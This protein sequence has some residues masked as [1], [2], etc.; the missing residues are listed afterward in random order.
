MEY[1]IE[2]NGT[3]YGVELTNSTATIFQKIK[4]GRRDYH[5]E[6]M[7]I[8]DLDTEEEDSIPKDSVFV[9][10]PM[11]GTVIRVLIKE[12]EHIHSGDLLFVLESMKMENDIFSAND[13]IVEKV[14]V[15]KGCKVEIGKVLLALNPAN[16]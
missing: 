6:A 10:A 7:E 12:G 15:E 16:I 4:T 1:I 8:P 5:K 14:F 9:K 11:S 13:A 2:L 3:K